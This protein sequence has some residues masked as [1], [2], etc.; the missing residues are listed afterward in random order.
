MSG[1]SHFEKPYFPKKYASLCI[2]SKLQFREAS[3]AL[4]TAEHGGLSP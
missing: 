3:L 1:L 4:Y 2:I